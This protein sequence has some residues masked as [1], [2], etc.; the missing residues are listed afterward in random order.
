MIV[1]LN[2]LSS[3]KRKKYWPSVDFDDYKIIELF[4][5]DLMLLEYLKNVS[6]IL[7]KGKWF[8][9]AK[10]EFSKLED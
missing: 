4:T 3:S 7:G 8:E 9:K 1:L 5:N 10:N 6:G 2:V